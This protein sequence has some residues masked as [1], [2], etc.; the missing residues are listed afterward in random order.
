MSSCPHVVLSRMPSEDITP[1]TLKGWGIV[2]ALSSM[3]TDVAS[4]ER[5]VAT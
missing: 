1:T 3:L 4:C 2:L 5:F